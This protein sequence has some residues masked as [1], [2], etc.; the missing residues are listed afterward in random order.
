MAVTLKL[1]EILNENKR[2]MKRSEAVKLVYSMQVEM[3]SN[4][5]DTVLHR[6]GKK[7]T[8]EHPKLE[9][10]VQASINL[11]EWQI[12]FNKEGSFAEKN[13]IS[14]MN[15]YQNAANTNTR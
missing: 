6:S 8:Q 4:M 10:E 2:N 13:A 12:K 15:R 11:L 9:T 5:M 1:N 14:V 7:A 3:T